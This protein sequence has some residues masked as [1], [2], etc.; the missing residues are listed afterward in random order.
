MVITDVKGRSPIATTTYAAGWQGVDLQMKFD[1]VICQKSV[2]CDDCVVENE[3]P[4][5]AFTRKEGINRSR[6]FNCGTCVYLCPKAFKGN[7]GTVTVK[8]KT[9]PIVCRQS[10]RFNAN[11]MAIE[12]KEKILKEEFPLNLPVAKIKYP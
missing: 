6:C 7:L 8:G 12:L 10:D 9:I 2:E 4:T 5:G 3:C 11:K 1:K